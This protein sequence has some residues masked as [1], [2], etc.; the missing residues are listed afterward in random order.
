MRIVQAVFM[1]AVIYLIS[2]CSTMQE[3][4]LEQN[5]VTRSIKSVS[6]VAAE[7]NSADM[8]A[9]LKAAVAKEGLTFGPKLEEGTKTSKDS[10]ALVSYE[11]VWRWDMAM[12]LKK[13][14]VRLYDAESGDLIA[15]GRWSNS[16]IDDEARYVIGDLIT[17][18]RW[19]NSFLHGY[20]DSKA[21][22]EGLFGEMMAKVRSI[23]KSEK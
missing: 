2:G 8:D 21:V 11:D 20:S 10:D 22:T 4:T 14:T 5:S 17:V 18:G 9:N 15:V 6:Q 1:T 19:L 3:V 16:F 7:G 12:Y 23:T 13:L